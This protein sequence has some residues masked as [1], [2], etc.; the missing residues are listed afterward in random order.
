MKAIKQ[1][2]SLALVIGK[3]RR[4]RV[5]IP[6]PKV[7]FI[8]TLFSHFSMYNK[9]VTKFLGKNMNTAYYTNNLKS[10]CKNYFNDLVS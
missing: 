9:T 2:L 5:N 1:C 6:T 4:L 3:E 8:H 10:L 7:V